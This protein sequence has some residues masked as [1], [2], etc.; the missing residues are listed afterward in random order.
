MKITFL[1][2]QLEELI[3]IFTIEEKKDYVCLLKKSLYD[4]NNL[5]DSGIR[6]LI[7]SW[8]YMNIV[9]ANMMFVS[10]LEDR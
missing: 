10:F 6:D 9:E 8:L 7:H 5:Q 1:H 3:Y 4:R 2:E